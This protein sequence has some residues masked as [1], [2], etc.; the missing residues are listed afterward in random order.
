M[1]QIEAEIRE[2][3]YSGFKKAKV[4]ENFGDEHNGWTVYLGSR[5]GEK[6][7]RI[8]DKLAESMG[9]IDSIRW[10]VEYKGETANAVFAMLLEFPEHDEQYQRQLIDIAVS[11]VSFIDKIDKNVSR[12]TLVSWWHEWLEYLQSCPLKPRVLRA[13]TSI[14]RKRAWVRHSVAKSL[15]MLKSAF[16]DREFENYLKSILEYGKSKYRE[17][18]EILI[19]DYLRGVGKVEYC[20]NIE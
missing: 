20:S 9:K 4:I 10:E 14:S 13:T 15:A 2:G 1:S 18:D 8:Y 5:S 19:A 3:N 11:G 17:I 16:D 12:N 7:I 6:M